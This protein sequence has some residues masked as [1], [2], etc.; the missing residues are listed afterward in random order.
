[1]IKYFSLSFHKRPLSEKK[2]EWLQLAMFPNL[3]HENHH[4]PFSRIFLFIQEYAE[5]DPL[6]LSV[7]LPSFLYRNIG[8]RCN[9]GVL[10]RSRSFHPQSTRLQQKIGNKAAQWYHRKREEKDIDKNKRKGQTKG[11]NRSNKDTVYR[12]NRPQG[13]TT[14]DRN[15]EFVLQEF[16]YKMASAIYR[17][18][19]N[20]GRPLEARNQQTRLW[21][22][23]EVWKLYHQDALS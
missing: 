22:P 18:T 7:F 9:D 8:N 13:Q 17:E 2:P 6:V 3:K 1:M 5:C 23:G 12:Q 11:Q 21:M 19:G 4:A 10:P 15:I 16:K 14:Q 20:R